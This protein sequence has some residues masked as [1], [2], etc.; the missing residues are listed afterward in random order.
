MQAGV[1][2]FIQLLLPTPV[3]AGSDAMTTLTETRESWRTIKG[4]DGV[5]REPAKGLWTGR[6]GNRVRRCRDGRGVTDSFESRVGRAT[7][8]NLA[9]LVQ[10][11]EIMWGAAS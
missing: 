6:M 7:R 4:C 11:E 5:C 2:V 10:S 8:G 9:A 1:M 3:G